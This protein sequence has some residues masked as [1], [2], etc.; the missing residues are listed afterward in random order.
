[1]T[2]TE[3]RITNI[4]Y[5]A[6]S[7]LSFIFGAASI[8][9]NRCYYY[10]YKDYQ[11]DSI[12][13]IVVQALVLISTF[14]LFESFQWFVLL[15]DFVGCTVL[16]AIRE[17][18]LISLVVLGFCLAIHLS[19][20]MASPKCLQI[21]TEEKQ[22][23]YKM[24]LRMYAIASLVV[25]VLFVPWPFI[26]A[27]KYGR[28]D[29]ICWLSNTYS[30]S[31]A[32]DVNVL[33]FV[34]RLLMWYLWAILMWLFAVIV[35]LLALCR[36]CVHKSVFKGIKSKPNVNITVLMS[37]LIAVIIIVTANGIIS[38]VKAIT[39]KSSFPAALQAAVITPLMFMA[40]TIINAV[41][42][43]SVIRTGFKKSYAGSIN[44]SIATLGRTYGASATNFVVPED[45]WD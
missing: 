20:L 7:F 25:P 30:C 10:C 4:V 42:Q 14:E 24:L 17:Y 21:I 12:Q 26:T 44:N 31:N 39:G 37:L 43:I 29:Y 33:E 32:S 8:L 3:I 13:G 9:I 18:I 40:Y 5:T 22:N 15:N 19:I 27:Y 6:L 35:A 16:G 41:R 45:E 23:R 11:V 34:G 36:Y 2:Y 1:M 38:A 28:D